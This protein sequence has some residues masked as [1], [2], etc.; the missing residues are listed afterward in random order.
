MTSID[1]MDSKMNPTPKSGDVQASFSAQRSGR[2]VVAVGCALQVT[3]AAMALGSCL[4][5]FGRSNI[6]PDAFAAMTLSGLV[7]TA[8]TSAVLVMYRNEYMREERV[9]E[10]DENGPSSDGGA[11]VTSSG[12]SLDRVRVD[13]DPLYTA[14]CILQG[15]QLSLFFAGATSNVVVKAFLA[16]R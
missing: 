13:L 12:L 15:I 6:H 11:L 5:S 7:I 14:L 1:A 2:D 10:R 16:L 3:V 8:V 9:L 4:T